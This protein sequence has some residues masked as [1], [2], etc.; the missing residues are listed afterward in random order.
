MCNCG[1]NKANRERFQVVLPSGL[2]VTKNSET[3]AKEFAAKHPGAVVKKA[4]A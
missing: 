3:A 2:K 1:K 4:A